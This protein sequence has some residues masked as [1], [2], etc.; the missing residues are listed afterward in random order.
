M[1][2]TAA[3]V[4]AAGR[5]SRFRAA[6]GAEETKLV[7]KLDG[8]PI[9]RRV[10]EAALLACR[11]GHCRGRP[12]QRR[13]RG[14]CRGFAGDHRVQFGL[15]DGDRLLAQDWP[16]RYAARCRRRS[17]SA[18]RHAERRSEPHRRPDRRVQGAADLSRSRAFPRGAARK[19]GSPRPEPVRAGD[20][21]RRRRRGA[22]SP[23][24]SRSWRRRGN[25]DRI[26]RVV[27]RRYARRSCQNAPREKKN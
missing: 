17:R 19:S 18:R 3:V 9:V 7:A 22:T 14:R 12:C 8:E 23:R 6:G 16:R 4:L 26:R 20:A 2:R 5:S 27:R 1:A 10:V 11:S 25:R 13:S 15:R 21:S 24:G